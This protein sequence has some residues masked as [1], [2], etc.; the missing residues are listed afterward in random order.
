MPAPPPP[1]HI[2]RP[3]PLGI[4][5]RQLI[6]SCTPTSSYKHLWYATSTATGHCPRT[7]HA[8]V[9][10]ATLK[11]NTSARPAWVLTPSASS[12][13][14]ERRDVEAVQVYSSY[15][16]APLSAEA[17]P[18]EGD[19][20]IHGEIVTLLMRDPKKITPVRHTC[21]RILVCAGCALRA[22]QACARHS[23]LYDS[24]LR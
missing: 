4:L 19:A 2:G 24:V 16:F 21:M 14:A 6:A 11:T 7:S 18:P 20:Y 22:E 8:A 12:W 17:P 10:E 5:P 15:P 1:C 3:A 23:F 13:Q 9:L